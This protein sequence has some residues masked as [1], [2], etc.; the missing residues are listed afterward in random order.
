MLLRLGPL[1]CFLLLALAGPDDLLW[2]V[3]SQRLCA[4]MSLSASRESFQRSVSCELART[5]QML[6]GG[7]RRKMAQNKMHRSWSSMRASILDIRAEGLSSPSSDMSRM[8]LACS[9]SDGVNAA[10]RQP[11]IVLYFY[12]V[13]GF[14]M[15]STTCVAVSWSREATTW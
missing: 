9:R 15:R 14:A 8:V 3:L 11:L 5:M 13:G 1:W 12:V 6:S 4:W 7:R 10:R 2:T